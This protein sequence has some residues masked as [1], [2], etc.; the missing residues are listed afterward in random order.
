MT[1]NVHPTAIIED[2]ARLGDG[3]VVNAYAIVTRHAVLGEGVVVHPHAVVGGDPQDLRFDTSLATGV[4]IGARTVI[5]EHVTLH[6][7]TKPD[8][9][10]EIGADCYLMVGSHIAHDCR[11]ADR[12]IVAN[13]VMFAGHIEVGEGAFIGGGA[14]IHQF[15]RIGE[16]AIVGGASRISQDVPPFAMVTERDEIV[17][18]NVVGLRRRSLPR[19]TVEELK[20]AFR[21]VNVPVGNMREIAAAELASG[22]YASAEARRYL[23]FFGAGKRSIARSRRGGRGTG[24]GD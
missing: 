20:K 2:G 12:V 22:A 11:L 5:R 14:A 24:S 16:G 6:R 7:A 21:A 8:G 4:R 18:L 1:V 23:E 19:T 15:S 10:T 3:C 9:W 17:G 13:N